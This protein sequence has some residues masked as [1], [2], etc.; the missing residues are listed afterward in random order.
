[1]Q[2]NLSFSPCK[3]VMEVDI[4]LQHVN[5]HLLTSTFETILASKIDGKC[6]NEG[7]VKPHSIQVNSFSGGRV[8]GE[9][10]R[11]YVCFDC[12]VFLPSSGMH[13]RSKVINV[14]KAGIQA[15][16]A[17]EEPSPYR[18]FVARDHFYD[19]NLFARLKVGHVF[20]GKVLTFRY[21]LEDEHVS[22]IGKV[23]PSPSTSSPP[24]VPSLPLLT[25][26]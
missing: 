25:K 26:T 7:Y 3:L 19:S 9:N 14:T 10:I 23:V 2:A 20:V 12:Q 1:M 8:Q 17:D 11:F 4:P 21:E 5:E 22:L 18:L 13:L 16:S 15:V 6:I 24:S